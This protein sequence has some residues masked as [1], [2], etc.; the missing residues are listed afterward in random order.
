MQFSFKATA[1]IINAIG[2]GVTFSAEALEEFAADIE[3]QL[4]DFQDVDGN[5]LV[6]AEIEVDVREVPVV[7]FDLLAFIM[8]FE[9][10]EV[11]QE[12]L[13]EGFQHLIDT[14]EAW[15]LQGSYGRTAISLIE[16][17]LCTR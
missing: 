1:Q 5:R 3:T 16:Q 11:S 15:T 8:D 2:E 9:N 6:G 12:R 7:E 14:G 4:N 13:V 10:G 17:G